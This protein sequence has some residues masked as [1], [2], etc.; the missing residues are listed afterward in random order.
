MCICPCVNQLRTKSR[1]NW[2]SGGSKQN[3][4]SR[5]PDE[6]VIETLKPLFCSILA[7]QRIQS[8]TM[9]AS[10]VT[11]PPQMPFPPPLFP[12]TPRTTVQVA[13]ES[14]IFLMIDLLAFT[15]NLLVCLAMY[16]N[17]RLR[18]T[19]NIY[20]TALALS[21]IGNALLV[22]PMTVG[23]IMTGKW[24]SGYEGCKV[25]GF[26]NLFF[27]YVSIQ[28]MAL[29]AINR[30]FRV[31][32]SKYY[33]KIFSTKKSITYIVVL[34]ACISV[35][36]WLPPTAS[37]SFYMFFP[38][39]AVCAQ[40]S[41]ESEVASVVFE[42]IFFNVLPLAI[43]IFSYYNVSKTIRQH[44]ASVATTLHSNQA[45]GGGSSS[46]SVEEIRITRTLFALVVG[47]VFCTF[48]AFTIFGLLR[49]QVTKLE[50]IPRPLSLTANALIFISS[51]INPFLYGVMNKPFRQEFKAILSCKWGNTQVNPLTSTSGSSG[52]STSMTNKS[53]A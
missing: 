42:A 5:L 40:V 25:H 36:V 10:N 2:I 32:K 24:V 17:P 13:F 46:L 29:T 27:G 37:L 11:M 8:F 20:I 33:K 16:R 45:S 15:G 52:P 41:L 9:P 50:S 7:S 53:S 19:T 49:L 44:N 35:I 14:M 23:T 6:F 43:I 26:F 30:Y 3:V 47:F 39:N 12:L 18:T 51:A 28:T 21:D 1:N 34:W 22:Q 4:L 31:V 38:D 48:P